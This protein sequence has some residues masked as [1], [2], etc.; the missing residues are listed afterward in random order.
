M[1]PKGQEW[2]LEVVH[3]SSLL[4]KG[5]M[6]ANDG[7]GVPMMEELPLIALYSN[8]KAILE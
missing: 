1:A 6:N 2:K 8:Q 4:L 5:I 3:P 7:Q